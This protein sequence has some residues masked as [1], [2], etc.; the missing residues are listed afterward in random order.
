MDLFSRGAYQTTAIERLGVPQAILLDGPAGINFF[1]GEVTA[2][3]YPT[4]AVIAATWN[5]ELAYAMGDAIGREADAYGVQGWYAP[6]MN[7]H[8]TAQGGRNFEYYSEDPLL[9]GKMGAA[10]TAGPRATT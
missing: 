10:M 9:S 8:R 2:A 6:G 5:D 3:S 7:L 1:F 4:Q